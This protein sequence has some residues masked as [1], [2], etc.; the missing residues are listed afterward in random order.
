MGGMSYFQKPDFLSGVDAGAIVLGASMISLIPYGRQLLH[1]YS[2]L[3]LLIADEADSKP[4]YLN[5]LATIDILCRNVK[6]SVK[7]VCISP[8]LSGAHVA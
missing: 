1:N 8:D 3:N 4:E 5:K 6:V 7:Q 2:R